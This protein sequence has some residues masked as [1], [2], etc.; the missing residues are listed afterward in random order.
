LISNN[1]VRKFANGEPYAIIAFKKEGF[2]PE[3][4]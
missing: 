1:F 3:V 2:F 4:L